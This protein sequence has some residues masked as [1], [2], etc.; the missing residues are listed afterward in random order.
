MSRAGCQVGSMKQITDWNQKPV[1]L[2][3]ANNRPGTAADMSF[4][5]D[6]LHGWLSGVSSPCGFSEQLQ[7]ETATNAQYSGNIGSL[8]WRNTVNGELHKYDYSYDGLGR[9]TDAQYSSSVN[10]T[11]GRFDETVTY[12]PNGSIMSLQRN[13]MKNNGTFGLIDSLVISYDGNRLLKVTDYAET[14]NYNGALDFDDGDDANCEYQYDSN[15]ALTYDSN[16][17]ISSIKYDYSH[18][19]SSINMPVKM[20]SISNDYTPDGRKLSNP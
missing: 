3:L 18:H 20:M 4:Y 2:I 14:L 11:A 17:G 15:G 1:P 16:R 6:T 7:R 8:Q 9:L 19:P 13:G 10:G 12:N 5:Y